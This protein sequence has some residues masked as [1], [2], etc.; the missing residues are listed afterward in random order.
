[1]KDKEELL[2]EI[3]EKLKNYFVSKNSFIPGKTKIPLSDKKFDLEEV[4]ESIESLISGNVT[5]GEKVRKFEKLFADYIGVAYSVMVNS[6][7]SANLLALSVL[8]NHALKDRIKPGD[9]IITPAVTWAT[10]IFPICNVNAIPVLVDIDPET[11][12]IDFNNIEK[13]INEN[14]KAI[15]PVHLVGNPCNMK[16]IMEIAEKRN[17]YVIEDA[18]EAHGAEFDGKKVGSFGDFSTFSFYFSH[19]ITTIEGGMLLTDNEELYEL[20]KALRVFGWTRDLNNKKE[21]AKKYP[22]F[23]ERWTFV[24]SGYNFRP[25]EI[26]GAFGIHQIKKLD[27]FLKSRRGNAEYLLNRLK[28]YSE[29]LSFQKENPGGKNAWLGFSIT[30]KK[31]A[32]FTKNEFSAYLESKGI[33]TRPIMT[34]NFAKQP[35]ATNGFINY[36]TVGKL[37]NSDFITNNSFLFG[38]HS[39]IDKKEI[40][41]IA[42]C[43]EE[44]LE[45]KL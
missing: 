10:T 30:I 13:A 11:L 2:K 18:C 41:Y 12:T 20:A 45:K 5:M 9:E 32:P 26:Q 43:I 3:E 6:G 40:E 28:K 7:S 23:D 34:G 37:E 35:V 22:Q 1:M 15:M 29:Y 25:T 36:K 33:E 14:T 44:F 8:T 31:N 4:M 17:L 16:E 21:L 24:N 27:A 42:H 39:E 38:I 19:H